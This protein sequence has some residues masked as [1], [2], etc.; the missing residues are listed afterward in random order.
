MPLAVLMTAPPVCVAVGAVVPVGV[1]VT[2]EVVKVTLL[3]GAEVAAEDV[4]ESA[5]EVVTTTTTDVLL[6]TLELLELTLDL[7]LEELVE[8]LEVEVEREVEVSVLT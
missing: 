3:V 5:S 4:E 1:L 8:L 7:E 6:A 2:E